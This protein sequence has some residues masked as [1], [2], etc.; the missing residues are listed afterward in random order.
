MTPFDS[1]L[2]VGFGGPNAPGEILPFLRNVVAGRGVPDARLAEVERHYLEVGGRSPY[3]ELAERQRAALERWLAGHGRPLPV[4]VGMRNWHPYLRDTLERMRGDGRR[5]AAGVILAAHR[6][7]VSLERYK[8]E[9]A[10]AVAENG[11]GGGGVPE[12][13]YLAPWYDAPRFLE[14]NASLL[15]SATGH[16]RGAWPRELPVVFSAHSIPLA[17]AT[18]SPYVGDLTASCEGVARIL[19]LADW[20]LAYQ[21]RSGD[22]RVPWLEP[23]VNDVLKRRAAAGTREVALQ[24]IGFLSDHV[25][26][27]YDLDHAA[28]DTA[29][30]VG[31]TLHRAPCVND[32]PEFI[33]LLGERILEPR[34][35]AP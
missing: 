21:S 2:L 7:E 17:M 11:G 16:R 23:D 9:V 12:V 14:A 15:E 3:N 20:E 10:R 13:R 18:G 33:A 1:V 24:A 35:E 34:L 30:G 22:P 29:A 31:L 28:R 5:S 4:Y 32:H 6:S 8:D 19:G 26:V 25:E 27:L